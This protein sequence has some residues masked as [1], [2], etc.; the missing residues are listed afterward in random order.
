VVDGRAVGAVRTRA[1][2]GAQRDAH[3]FTL[4]ELLLAIAILGIV[5]NVA[6]PVVI[7][8][9]VKADAAKVLA[10]VDL[11]HDA[12]LAYRVE[13]GS[14]PPTSAWGVVPP[15]LAPYLPDG[16][17]FAYKDVRYRYQLQRIYKRIGLDGGNRSSRGRPIVRRAGEL[18]QGQKTVTARRVFLWL[19][20]P[21]GRIE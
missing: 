12:L 20:S 9:Q 5:V 21:G 4:L 11:I 1:E 15:G 7:G 8:G 18:F 3:G 6:V 13:N 10:D 2:I 16:F 17:Q 19:P 14:Y